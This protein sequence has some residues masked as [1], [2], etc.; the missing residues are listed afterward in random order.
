M[1]PNLSLRAIA[2]L[3]STALVSSCQTTD[4]SSLTVTSPDG[5]IVVTVSNTADELCYS[6]ERAERA[7]LECSALGYQ[8]KDQ[9]PV[10]AG[11]RVVSA[12]TRTVDEPWVLPWG[13]TQ[14]VRDHFNELSIAFQE[15]GPQARTMKVTFR[16]FDDGLGFR[17]HIP[18]ENAEGDLILM[19]ELTEFVFAETLDA[20]WTPAYQ[21]ARYE[22][23]YTKSPIG[24]LGEVHT[25]LTLTGDE[26]A[27]SLHEAALIDY[28]GMVIEGTGTNV[29]QAQLVPWSTGEKAVSDGALTSSWRTIQI[30]D[31]SHE[32]IN[33][34]LILSLNEPSEIEDTDW[35]QPSKYV[36]IWWC[37]HLDLCSWGSGDKHGATNERTKEYIDFAA[38]H[39]FRGVLVEGWNTGW[40]GNWTQNGDLFNFT[41]PH[42][43]FDLTMLVEY[44]DSK[45]VRLIG[46]HET[47]ASSKN[48]EAQIEAA[49][50]LYS[51]L[52][53]DTVKTGHVGPKLDGTE[54]HHGQYGVQHF[55]KI[56][57]VAA[58]YQI[59]LNM[60]EPIKDTGLRRTYPHLMTREGARGQEFNA[61][62]RDGG[63]PPDHTTILPFTRMLSGPMDFTPGIFELELKT[64][65][66]NRV[67]TT[68]AKQLALYVVIYSPLH[69]AADLPENYADH[70]ALEFIE[71][72]PVDWSQTIALNGEI[73]DYVSIARKD[74]NSEDWYVGSITDE[75]QRD[76]S[77]DLNFLDANATYE[78]TIY[79]DGDEADWQTNPIDYEIEIR[80]GL[81]SADKLSLS[82]APG[83]GA[84][85]QLR[86]S[87]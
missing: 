27:I 32:L 24:D 2:A 70:P 84:A 15:A 59:M 29:L 42:P 19:D 47:G 25:P 34:N 14:T 78:A 46:H 30:A 4:M 73:G 12:D 53:I 71:R 79:K 1:K 83:G 10:G 13:E 49:F 7:I 82:L 56:A 21:R 52:G 67:S 50:K 48:Y 43:D 63:N 35:I 68:L 3:L 58:K 6:V 44:A 33:S 41:E 86:P 85:V 65:P 45:G 81:T 76:I 61:W 64:K 5:S 60:H 11:L 17:Y 54:W 74:R 39:G 18:S 22:Y 77:I 36:G 80:T 28:P 9:E 37:M 38:A 31:A 23:L 40:D 57:E 72:V 8:L 69:M 87:E 62:S 16:V 55:Q 51:E 26:I 66:G 20:F 75:V